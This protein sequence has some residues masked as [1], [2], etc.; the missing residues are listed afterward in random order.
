MIFFSRVDNYAY[1]HDSTDCK[2]TT[3]L[4]VLP[5]AVPPAAL[6]VIL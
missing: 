1:R 3:V 5:F 4:D 6:T 2:I